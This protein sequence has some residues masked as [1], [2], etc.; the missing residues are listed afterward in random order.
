MIELKPW[1]FDILACPI[2]KHF[3]LK[4]F[5]FSF[6]NDDGEF[7]LYLNLYDERDLS[8]IKKDN[9]IQFEIADNEEEM[10]V[11]DN[12]II[13]KQ[14]LT[15][16]INLIISSIDELNNIYNKTTSKTSI[17][18]FNLITSEIKEKILDFSKNFKINQIEDILPELSFINKIKIDVEIETGLLFCDKCLRWFPIIETIPQML[19][20]EYRDEKKDVDF[21]NANKKLLEEE[22][23][24]KNLKPFNIY[25]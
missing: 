6:N 22:F 16:Y 25:I 3:P 12:I 20:D 23:L 5:I 4:L 13:E 1:L 15:K 8:L 14:S 24:N 10:L 18:C 17:K 7:Q 2:D 9:V 11:R 19:P 21:L